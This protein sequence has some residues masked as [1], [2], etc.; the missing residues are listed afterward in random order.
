MTI[1]S[2]T[3][4]GENKFGLVTRVANVERFVDTTFPQLY[5]GLRDE[6][7]KLKIALSNVRNALSDLGDKCAEEFSEENKKALQAALELS[8]GSQ[9]KESL[10]NARPIWTAFL[11]DITFGLG[12][13]FQKVTKDMVI[14]LR[15]KMIKAVTDNDDDPELEINPEDVYFS[16]TF[17]AGCLEKDTLLLRKLV[18]LRNFLKDSLINFEMLDSEDETMKALHPRL[19]ELYNMGQDLIAYDNDLRTHNEVGMT[20]NDLLCENRKSELKKGLVDAL[21]ASDYALG[22]GVSIFKMLLRV[23]D[24]EK[25]EP[26]KELQNKL[27]ETTDDLV[28]NIAKKA[29]KKETNALISKKAAVADFLQVANIFYELYI[30]FCRHS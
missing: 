8:G 25:L 26:L 22:R 14:V 20:L 24:L 13:I 10:D 28:M 11:S 5:Q 21:E 16:E 1:L 2:G 6:D 30:Y 29:D 3:G 7:E 12:D 17:Q 15:S 18:A 27:R 19:V 9:L 4:E 23:D